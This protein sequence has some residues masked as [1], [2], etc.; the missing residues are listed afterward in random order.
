[1][2]IV[3]RSICNVPQSQVQLILRIYKVGFFTDHLLRTI[4]TDPLSPKSSGL[5]VTI[6]DGE[7][8][9]KDTKETKYYGKASSTAFINGV[10]EVAR[11]VRSE[12]NLPVPCGT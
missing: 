11:D 10:E 8:E 2:K 9:C 6:R 7:I 4:S 12:K 1:M 5:V 3:A